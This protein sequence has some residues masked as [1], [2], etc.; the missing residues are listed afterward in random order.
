MFAFTEKLSRP[1]RDDERVRGARRAQDLDGSAYHHEE[2]NLVITDVDEHL[3]GSQWPA[4]SMR[5]EAR[6]LRGCQ[7][8][9]QPLCR[10]RRVQREMSVRH[11]LSNLIGACLRT[12]RLLDD[13][14][15]RPEHNSAV[16]DT[17]V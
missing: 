6:H 1:M 2:W 8:G 13:G 14:V 7:C 3:A 9:K 10:G 11:G 16:L 4:M 17:F 12:L 15:G 5:R